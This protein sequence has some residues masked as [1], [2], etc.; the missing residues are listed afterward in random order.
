MGS[1]LGGRLTALIR[2]PGCRFMV[3]SQDD[4]VLKIASSPSAGKTLGSSH[5]L[6]V[7]FAGFSSNLQDCRCVCDPSVCRLI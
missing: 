3:V 1:V 4:E 2:L 7:V 5:F 6:L